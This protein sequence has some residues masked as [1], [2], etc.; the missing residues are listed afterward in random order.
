MDS[1]TIEL[2]SNAFGELFP[3]K[4]LS[5]FTNFFRAS[6]IGGAMGGCKFRNI[7]LINVPKYNGGENQVF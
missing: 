7:L 1:F 6:K 2:D 5:S 3:N 4:T